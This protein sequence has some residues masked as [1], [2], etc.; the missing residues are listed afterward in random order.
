MLSPYLKAGQ[1]SYLDTAVNPADT[2]ADWTLPTAGFR[3]QWPLGGRASAEC[4]QWEPAL[5]A[6]LL[7]A[8][9]EAREEDPPKEHFN[10]RHYFFNSRDVTL[11]P[12]PVKVACYRKS[13]GVSAS[14]GCP[15]VW[16]VCESGI[17]VKHGCPWVLLSVRKWCHLDGVPL[18]QGYHWARSTMEPELSLSQGYPWI[19]TWRQRCPWVRRGIELGAS[20]SQGIHWV[21]VVIES[22][23]PVKSVTGL[24]VLI[25]GFVIQSVPLNQGCTDSGMHVNLM[26]VSRVGV[27][28]SAIKNALHNP[29]TERV[30]RFCIGWSIK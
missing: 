12:L 15:W 26:S 10:E 3:P 1:D 28:G 25:Q 9:A 27:P 4:V 16:D 11:L 17:F 2:A 21:T 5:V 7:W 20:W 19:G 24:V 13:W 30:Y 23:A 18:N 14:Q 22:G 29:S 6:G 8:A